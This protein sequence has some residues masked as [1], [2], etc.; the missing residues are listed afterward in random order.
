MPLPYS[1]TLPCGP[2]LWCCHGYLGSIVHYVTL[3]LLLCM[4]FPTCTH[5]YST[6]HTLPVLHTACPTL[7]TTLFT[8]AALRTP[9]RLA[10]PTAHTCLKLRCTTTSRNNAAL[11]H[12]ITCG[13]HVTSLRR[14][15]THALYLPRR[16][17]ALRAATRA[18]LPRMPHT[19]AP[20]AR[21]LLRAAPAVRSS[22]PSPHY[23][24]AARVSPLRA[25][26]TLA[27]SVAGHVHALPRTSGAPHHAARRFFQSLSCVPTVYVF[28]FIDAERWHWYAA[29]TLF[30]ACGVAARLTRGT[31]SHTITILPFAS[32]RD[33]TAR[34]ATWRL[35]IPYPCACR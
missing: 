11:R 23:A 2:L 15:A 17:C 10:L 13:A 34:C 12:F 31:C 14:S 4:P 33:I 30:M 32:H 35:R 28:L 22:R 27:T 29:V 25:A 7:P 16:T 9:A 20:F 8:C 19:H 21:R 6:I 3:L 5:I 1:C 24:N 26:P 18:Y